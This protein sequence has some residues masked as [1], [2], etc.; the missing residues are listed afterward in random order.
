M[1]KFRVGKKG[2]SL[3]VGKDVLDADGC[4]VGGAKLFG[5][6]FGFLHGTEDAFG[7]VVVSVVDAVE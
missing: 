2:F 1:D 5:E 6:C 3:E 4:F 7:K